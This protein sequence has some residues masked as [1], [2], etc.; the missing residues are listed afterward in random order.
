MQTSQFKQERL[1][2]YIRISVKTAFANINDTNESVF[3]YSILLFMLLQLSPLF[4][5]CPS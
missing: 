5:F 4:P 2:W 1:N 3:F